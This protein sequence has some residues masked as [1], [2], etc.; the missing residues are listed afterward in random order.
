[1]NQQK[2]ITYESKMLFISNIKEFELWV[3]FS[4]QPTFAFC[5]DGL[6]RKICHFVVVI[7]LLSF[8][9]IELTTDESSWNDK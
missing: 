7:I 3:E 8:L 2:I 9:L 6:V 1:M 5:F 4:N